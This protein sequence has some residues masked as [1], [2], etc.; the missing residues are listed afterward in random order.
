MFNQHV[1]HRTCP[2]CESRDCATAPKV[3][4]NGTDANINYGMKSTRLQCRECDMIWEE[5]D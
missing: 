2:R 4:F 1:L 5:A 3:R